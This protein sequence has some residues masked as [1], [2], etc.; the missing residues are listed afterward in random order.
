MSKNRGDCGKKVH[1]VEKILIHIINPVI[2]FAIAI[3]SNALYQLYCMN[4]IIITTDG[5]Y[6]N[7]E[8]KLGGNKI[9]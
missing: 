5:T 7:K 1:L 2:F 9:Q 8:Y 4:S 3:K 6:K